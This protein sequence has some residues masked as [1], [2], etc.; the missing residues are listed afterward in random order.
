MKI[1][2]LDSLT[3]GNDI[4]AER[5]SRFGEL[6]VYEKTNESEVEKRISDCDAVIVNKIKLNGGNLD[7][8]KNLRLICVTATGYDNIDIDYCRKRGIAVCNVV[9]YSADSVAQVTLAMALSLSTRL[10]RFSEYVKDGSYTKSGVA[11]MLSPVYHELRGKT[12]GILGAGS[13]GCQVAKCAEALGCRVIACKKTPVSYMNC[14]DADTLCRVSDI[15][16]V[17]VPLSA[18]TRGMIDRRRIAMMKSDAIFINVSRG[19]VTD[20]AAL[21]EAIKANKLGALGADVYSEEPFGIEHPFYGIRELENVCF[22]P[23]MAWGAY[24]ARERCLNETALNIE[25]FLRGEIRNRADV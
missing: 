13:I 10:N 23:H 4:S 9:G 18:E 1:T 19:A 3:L 24:E 5:F 21:A 15:I 17:H 11:N 7:G 8:A 20:E 12:W 25:A 6:C 22:T 14:V 2:V 16:S